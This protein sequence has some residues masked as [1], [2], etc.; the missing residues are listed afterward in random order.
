MRKESQEGIMTDISVMEIKI[1]E[2]LETADS[3]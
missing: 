3:N 1:I 2:I